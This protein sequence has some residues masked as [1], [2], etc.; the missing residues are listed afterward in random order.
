MGGNAF[1][2]YAVIK[3]HINFE[4]GRTFPS[5]DTIAHLS[6]CSPTSV[7]KHLKTLKDMGYLERRNV[8]GRA[9]IYKLREQ[10]DF[11]GKDKQGNQVPMS[12]SWDYIPMGVKKAV[13][14]I[15]HV[16]V[17]GNLPEGSKVHIEN[18]TINVQVLPE[19]REANQITINAVKD[20]GLRAMIDRAKL[21]GQGLLDHTPDDLD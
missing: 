20:E 18:L 12:A 4:T 21:R 15:R 6:G 10:L 19:A 11:L 5:I 16:I 17:S 3:S 8:K 1:L 2:V 9:P 7:R 14:D 13:E